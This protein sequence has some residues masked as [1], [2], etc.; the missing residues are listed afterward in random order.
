MRSQHIVAASAVDHVGAASSI[1]EVVAGPG[2]EV[3]ERLLADAGLRAEYPVASGS[4]EQRQEDMRPARVE[5]VVAPAGQHFELEFA[6]RSEADVSLGDA[7]DGLEVDRRA[8]ARVRPE[9]DALGIMRGDHAGIRGVENANLDLV[10]AVRLR[11]R[12]RRQGAAAKVDGG[13]VAAAD[14]DR[15]EPVEPAGAALAGNVLGA[16]HEDLVALARESHVVAV[17]ADDELIAFNGATRGVCLIRDDRA[18]SDRHRD[19]RDHARSS[20]DPCSH[21]ENRIDR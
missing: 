4:G 1:D 7:R 16:A 10:R 19:H 18:G 20:P 3:G 15:V 11:G 21:G 12:A 9:L 14:A 13:H 5:H 6:V 17:G 8:P 2:G